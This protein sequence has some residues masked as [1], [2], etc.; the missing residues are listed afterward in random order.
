MP[1]GVISTSGVGHF[2]RREPGG[3]SALEAGSGLRLPV[4]PADPGATHVVRNQVPALVD[5]DVAADP[6]LLEVLDREGAGWYVGD[7]HRLG[8]VAGGA[9]AQRW[10][11]LA[12]EH[13]PV[14]HTHDRYGSRGDEVEFHPAWHEL[15]RVAVG[16]GLAGALTWAESRPGA[17]V[18]R[19]AGLHT[20]VQ[21]DAGHIC[22]VTMTYAAR[23]AL[24]ADPR[25]TAEIGPLLASRS[26]DPD[27][28]PLPAKRGAVAGMSMTEKQGGSDLRAVGTTARPVQDGFVLRGHKW[29]TSAPTSDVFF[30][31]ARAPGGLSCFLLP[32]WLPDGTRNRLYYQRLK[33]KLGNHSNAS[34]EVEYADA[35]GILVGE[36][37]AGLRTILQM[38]ALTRLD[39]M[40]GSAGLMR[41]ALSQAAHHCRHR[42][43]FGGVLVDK[44]VMRAVLADLVLDSEAA[45]ALSLRVAGAVDRA[46]RGDQQ[47]R[48]FA[49][50]GTA[51]GKYWVCKRAVPFI[52]EALEC[53]G[54][55]GYV[56]DSGMPR[57]FRESPLNS[58]WEGSGNVNALDVLR[59][60]AC[61]PSARNAL[62]EELRAPEGQPETYRAAVRE[63]EQELADQDRL[64]AGARRSVERLAILLQASL[65]LRHA[66]E[67]IAHGFVAARIGNA[68]G[69]AYGALDNT[70]PATSILQRLPQLQ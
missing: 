27:P 20:W 50:I 65:L 12:E 25:L 26:Y 16:E 39:C 1:D 47:E 57:L 36:E 19:A 38:V 42:R 11:V 35:V 28:H 55:N 3:G 14:L 34:A 40:V 67:P 52:A 10:A 63:V 33:R 8:R 54:G 41:A 6:A 51:V 22:P 4:L 48:A 5:W 18:A 70:V 53:L 62:L 37:G 45:T 49:R 46:E 61:E 21:A 17:H 13:P 66:P 29:F 30:T 43:A 15:M 60:L 9:Q 56:E 2:G 58:I 23:A 69:L 31:L 59:V 44:P 32:R 68:G 64:E 24:R 7:L